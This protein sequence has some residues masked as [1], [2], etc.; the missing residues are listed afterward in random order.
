MSSIESE[1]SSGSLEGG[2]FHTPLDLAHATYPLI[3]VV[4][5]SSD[6]HDTSMVFKAEGESIDTVAQFIQGHVAIEPVEVS[7]TK[8]KKKI[9]IY[10]DHFVTM[11]E[12]PEDPASTLVEVATYGFVRD[13]YQPNFFSGFF[14][15]Y[16]LDDVLDVDDWNKKQKK[17]CDSSTGGCYGSY[18]GSGGGYKGP[19]GQPSLRGGSSSVRG[20]GPGTGK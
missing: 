8:D 19:I 18:G 4:K 3:D 15:W 20:G 9:I 14:L 2:L 13:N 12:D 7:E 10:E 1:L 6:Q 11:T 16:L 5:S 17:R